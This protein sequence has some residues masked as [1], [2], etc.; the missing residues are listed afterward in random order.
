MS[1]GHEHGKATREVPEARL[2]WALALT[3]GYLLAEV[4][5][6][7]VFGSLALLSDA[8]HMFTDV[9]GLLIALL[10]IRLGQR[11]ADPKRTFGY[12]RLEIL[13]AA[14]NAAVLFVVAFYILLEAYQRLREPAEV[15]SLPMLLV[16]VG[17]LAVNLI[18]ARLLMGGSRESLNM[19]GA[20]LE[21]LSDL[22]GS[23]AVIAGAV[24][25]FFTGWGWVDPLLGALIGL[26]VLPRTWVL[27]SASVN[28]LLEGVPEGADL[29]KLQ[30][31][32]EALPGVQEAH[33]LHVWATTGGEHNLSVH[34]VMDTPDVN[35]IPLARAVAEG[36]GIGHVTVQ[37]E[38]P[39]LRAAEEHAHPRWE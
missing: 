2:R 39:A 32:L 8:A 24:V 34:L 19:R 17:G 9:M 15:Q 14:V 7:L 13:A 26:W 22:L 5:G 16:A 36:H 38:T 31:E 3:G 27:L 35:V 21:V 33:D 30:A 25:I 1:R 12:R 11:P 23:V 4:V 29:L 20:Y 18:A 6:G 10:A 28:V 37:L